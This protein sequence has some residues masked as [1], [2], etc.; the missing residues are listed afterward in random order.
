MYTGSKGDHLNEL[1][2]DNGIILHEPVSYD[3]LQK[4]ID[5]SEFV[6]HVES[7]DEDIVLDLKY[8]FTT[9]IADMLAS[10]RCPVVYGPDEIASIKYFKDTNSGCV[11][12]SKDSLQKMLSELLDDRDLEELYVR[13]ALE[14]AQNYHNPDINAESFNE[15]L[16]SVENPL[17]LK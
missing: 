10:G 12:S 9:K 17:L 16:S 6:V 1:N 4:E 15:L 7:F 8:A 3:K 14:L 2:E 5:N 13:N 11:I